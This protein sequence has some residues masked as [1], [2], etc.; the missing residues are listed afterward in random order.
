MEPALATDLYQLTMAGGYYSEGRLS[1]A[2]FELS[3]RDL[4]INRGYFVAAG[5]ESALDYLSDLSF[6]QDEV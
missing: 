2:S 1:R 4:A 3:V 6:S 5:L